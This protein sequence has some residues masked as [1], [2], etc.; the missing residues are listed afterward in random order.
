MKSHVTKQVLLHGVEGRDGQCSFRTIPSHA[1]TQSRV[2][3]QLKSPSS[4]CNTSPTVNNVAQNQCNQTKSVSEYKIWHS[5]L[6]HANVNTVNSIFKSCNLPISN[7]TEI[8]FCESCR[9]GKSHKFPALLSTTKHTHAFEQFK[10]TIQLVQSDFDGDFP[11]FTQ[12]LA[13]LGITH[14]FTCPYTSH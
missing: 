1:T 7:K 5:R 14:R 12:H 9:L 8:P 3:S 11:P 2:K 13:N 4:R 10:A 6:G